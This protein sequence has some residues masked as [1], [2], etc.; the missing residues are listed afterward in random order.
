[1]HLI[2]LLPL[3]LS[4]A[5]VLPAAERPRATGNV[6][7]RLF[8]ANGSRW[9]E[10]RLD[11]VRPNSGAPAVLVSVFDPKTKQ[12][13]WAVYRGLGAEQLQRWYLPYLRFVLEPG[14]QIISF[15]MIETQLQVRPVAMRASSLDAGY[16]TIRA[17]QFE[18]ALAADGRGAWHTLVPVSDHRFTSCTTDPG[19]SPLP[20]LRRLKIIDV[21]HENRCWYI[22][23]KNN[24]GKRR[25][26]TLSHSFELLD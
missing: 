24:C 25:V 18:A 22:T 19:K 8:T 1:M 16:A 6:Q 12:F 11:E 13:W 23:L 7:V 15:D 20:L 2:R 4:A 17:T 26:V 10:A 14:T 5:L 9:G 21:Q 3:V